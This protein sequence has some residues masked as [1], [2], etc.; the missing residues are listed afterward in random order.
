MTYSS[1]CSPSPNEHVGYKEAVSIHL[2]PFVF[3]HTYLVAL[4]IFAS[5]NNHL[6]NLIKQMQVIQF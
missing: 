5:L 4:S 2:F 3:L 6:L 1:D